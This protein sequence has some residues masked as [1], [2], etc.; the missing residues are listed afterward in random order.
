MADVVVASS[1]VS[2]VLLCEFLLGFEALL[3][4]AV[5]VSTKGLEMRRDVFE[6]L[7]HSPP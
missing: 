1:C 2:V 7:C 6:L 3:G 5:P 4:D